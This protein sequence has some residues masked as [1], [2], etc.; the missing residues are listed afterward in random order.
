MIRVIALLLTML[1]SS[2]LL[3]EVYRWIDSG[4]NVHYGDRP[5]GNAEQVTLKHIPKPRSSP[6]STAAERKEL[7][8]RLL[9][10][11]SEER[12]EKKK[13]RLE[14]KAERKASKKK[15]GKAKS[16]L[17]RYNNSRVI[18][19]TTESGERE[20]YSNEKRERYIKYLNRQVTKWCG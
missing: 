2:P 8:H 17:V 6:V 13:K 9:K 10:V 4:G 3:S 15:C 7:Q 14:Q 20:Y 1:A 18:Y 19:N 12:E 11:F 16:E 5:I